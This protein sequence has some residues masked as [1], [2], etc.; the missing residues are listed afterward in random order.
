MEGAAVAKQLQFTPNPNQGVLGLPSMC[1]CL[2]W[3]SQGVGWDPSQELRW[4]D[5]FALF[6][7]AV[8]RQ[9]IAA[10]YAT[11]QTASSTAYEYG[12]T[13]TLMALLTR[14]A[15]EEI[16]GKNGNSLNGRL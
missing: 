15:I 11:R 7:G 1:D 16:N 8:V 6:R 13:R 2:G 3:Y 4:A 12:K 14:R 9:G 5:A 10:R